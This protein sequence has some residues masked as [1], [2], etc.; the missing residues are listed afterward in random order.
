M[1]FQHY[2]ISF[3]NGDYCRLKKSVFDINVDEES[4]TKIPC[5]Q[6][7][8]SNDFREYLENFNLTNN[9]NEVSEETFRE[10]LFRLAK[11]DRAFQDQIME[12]IEL[13]V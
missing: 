12:V 8:V 10:V 2:T 1:K 7:L 13:G 4:V 5:L 9:I 11:I 3:Y 6:I